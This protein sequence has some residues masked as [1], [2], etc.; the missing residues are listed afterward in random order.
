MKIQRIDEG[1]AFL[2]SISLN[3]C[4]WK[5]KRYYYVSFAWLFWITDTLKRF[6]WE[7]EQ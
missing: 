1:F 2:P 5:G 7:D 4:T 6:P 3:W